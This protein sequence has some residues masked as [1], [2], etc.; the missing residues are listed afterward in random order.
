MNKEQIKRELRRSACEDTNPWVEVK[1]PKT[2][3]KARTFCSDGEY[4]CNLK[5]NDCRTFF[6]L[7]AE[8]L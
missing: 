2:F 5:P 1:F 6:L 3:Q 7:C 4:M 8:A